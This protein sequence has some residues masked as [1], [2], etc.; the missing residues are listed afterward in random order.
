MK[1]K[2]LNFLNAIGKKGRRKTVS[3]CKG[4]GIKCRIDKEIK[5]KSGKVLKKDKMKRQN[6]EEI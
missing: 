3:R 6:A 5:A 4:E 1:W 2:I